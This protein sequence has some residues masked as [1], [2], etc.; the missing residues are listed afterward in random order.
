MKSYNRVEDNKNQ[1][2]E[3]AAVAN[4]ANKYGEWWDRQC[5]DYFQAPHLRLE[6]DEKIKLPDG[7]VCYHGGT[8]NIPPM[9]GAYPFIPIYGAGLVRLLSVAL[10]HAKSSQELMGEPYQYGSPKTFMDAGCGPGFTLDV[11]ELVGFKDNEGVEL[12]DFHAQYGRDKGKKIHTANMLDFDYRKF[13]V[14]Y[15]YVPLN[16]F[17][18][19]TDKVMSEA[20][21]GA[22]FVW[23]G[24]TSP[25]DQG[26]YEVVYNRSG[27]VVKKVAM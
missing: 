11:A 26:E 8:K 9:A 3:S 7:V 15:S 1:E 6:K 22:V 20:P 5:R 18:P 24:G 21:V 4:F 27:I 14:V 25:P 19:F 12:N 13:S 10:K 17:K 16:P 2:E 23:C